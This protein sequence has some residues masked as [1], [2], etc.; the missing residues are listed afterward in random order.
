MTQWRAIRRR[1]KR[2]VEIR[3]GR[4]VEGAGV[5]SEGEMALLIPSWGLGDINDIEDEKEVAIVSV[6]RTHR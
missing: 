1:R 6:P 5:Q 3:A 4:H 2:R